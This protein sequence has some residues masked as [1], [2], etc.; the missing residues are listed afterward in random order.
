M[1]SNSS[2]TIRY[3]NLAQQALNRSSERLASGSRINRAADDA[4]GL[5]LASAAEATVAQLGV[6]NNNISYGQSM[7]DIADSAMGEIGGIMARM[8]ELAAQAA[9]GTYSDEQR[10]SMEAERQ[11]LAEEVGRIAETTTFNGMKILNGEGFQV[12]VGTG[13]GPDSQIAVA[14][15]DIKALAQQLASQNIST[16]DGAKAAL[17]SLSGQIQSLASARGEM[18]AAMSRLEVSTENN[19]AAR[20]AIQASASRIRDADVAEE[21]ANAT[22]AKIRAQAGTAML[23][24]ANVNQDMVMKLLS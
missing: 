9:N 21:S 20:E 8:S 12:Q 5:A 3:T 16:Q 11:G 1:D 23:A 24:Q 7:L 22:A 14:G 15:S 2:S 10:A 6:A 18:G 19:A 13:S 4:A 17:D